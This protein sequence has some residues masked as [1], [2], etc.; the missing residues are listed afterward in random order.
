MKT[1]I[2]ILNYNSKNDTIRYVNEIKKYDI[3]DTIIVVDNKSSDPNEIEDLKKFMLFHQIKMVG[4]L[5]EI[6]LV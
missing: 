1:A 2:I 3:L 6:M 4:I 5:T